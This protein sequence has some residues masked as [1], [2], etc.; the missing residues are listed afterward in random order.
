MTRHASEPLGK[1]LSVTMLASRTDLRAASDGIPCGVGPFYGT[2]CVG[3]EIS[4]VQM[5]DL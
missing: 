3:I 5:I 4:I 1:R 2:S